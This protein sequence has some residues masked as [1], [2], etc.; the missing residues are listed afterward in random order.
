ML[1]DVAGELPGDLLAGI[2]AQARRRSVL[3]ELHVTPGGMSNR[4]GIV[5]R[6]ALPVEAV[7][8][9]AI[10][11]LASHFASLA[12]D[13][14]CGIGEEGRGLQLLANRVGYYL[15]V[16]HAAGLCRKYFS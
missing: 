4:A 7:G 5:V 11:L 6:K 3:N 16:T 15:V 2:A 1:A 13:A 9:N 8:F 14:Q 10:P 12:A